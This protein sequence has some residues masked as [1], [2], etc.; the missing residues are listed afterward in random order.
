MTRVLMIVVALT[1]SLSASAAAQPVLI[2]ED[3]IVLDQPDPYFLTVPLSVTPDGDGFL[4]TDAQAPRLFRYRGDGSLD[5]T[6]GAEGEGPGELEEAALAMP[7]RTAE[8]LGISWSPAAAQS[9]DRESGAFIDR[10]ALSGAVESAHL[11]GEVLWV[12]GVDY[13]S[14][15]AVRRVELES[16]SV[17]R[18]VTIPASY[19]PGAPLHGIFPQIP[20][21]MWGDTL[22]VGFEPLAELVLVDKEGS[23]LDRFSLPSS[24]RRGTPDDPE[25]VIL[26]VFRDGPYERVF[27][28]LSATRAL[29]RRSDGTILVV[30]YD[31]RPEPPPVTSEAFVSVVSADRRSV[32]LDA[33][34]PL[35]PEAQP[36]VGFRGDT[37]LVL[38][39]VIVGFD[40]Q[41]V[42]RFIDVDTANCRWTNVVR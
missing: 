32:C 2:V 9:F 17:E 39:Q 4:V 24:A 16:G 27:G 6:Y 8:I 15:T 22:L 36:A 20:I 40:V 21:A 10:Y 29:H 33:A 25:A 18:F 31:S 42:L 1:L 23:E 14:R 26:E 3:S 41:A 35:S 5:R 30:H 11:D 19:R 28:T 7:F 12:G 38:E 34:V 13:G 37:L